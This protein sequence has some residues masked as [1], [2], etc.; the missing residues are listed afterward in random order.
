MAAQNARSLFSGS[1]KIILII[2]LILFIAAYSLGMW[3]IVFLI[4][5]AAM[6]YGFLR[7]YRIPYFLFFLLVPFSIEYYLP[8]GFGT[9]LPTEP[10]MWVMTATSALILIKSP[11]S[12]VTDK[13]LTP[14]TFLLLLH[15]TWILVST[16]FSETFVISVKYLLAKLWYVI[17]FYFLSL[18]LIK[19]SEVFKQLVSLTFW[20]LMLVSL[21]ILI[22]HAAMGFTFDSVNH[23]VTP[24]FRNHV[25]YASTLVLFLPFIWFLTVS[26]KRKSFKLIFTLSIFLCLTAIYFSYTRAAILSAA[27]AFV[28]YFLIRMRWM[29]R[30]VLLAL[31]VLASIIYFLIKDNNYVY[32]APDYERTV[33]HSEFTNLLDATYKLED[34]STMERVYRWVAGAGMF[35]EKPWLGFGPGSFYSMYQHYTVRMFE[36]YVSD[37]PEH[38]GI[39]NY[40]LMVLVEQGIFGFLIFFA[41][42]LYVLYLFER[43]YHRTTL[44]ADKNMLMAAGLCTIIILLTNLINDTLEVDKIGPFFFISLAILSRQY[45]INRSKP[46][47]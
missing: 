8:G 20:P 29:F 4:P 45:Q 2:A 42:C 12:L 26:E 46:A 10:L 36:T 21:G 38:S 25:S 11:K 41:L 34:I 17:P 44:Q 31:P 6:L 47:A 35:S 13:Y 5:A 28:C 32:F 40:F 27:I 7:D 33:M 43:E 24:I 23:V 22:R 16:L 14:I 3:W 39:H 37:N 15:M 19:N 30:S 18:H 9:D 1:W